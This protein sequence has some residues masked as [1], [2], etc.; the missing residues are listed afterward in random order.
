MRF[1]KT[2]IMRDWMELSLKQEIDI[3]CVIQNFK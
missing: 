2:K 3:G 1:K